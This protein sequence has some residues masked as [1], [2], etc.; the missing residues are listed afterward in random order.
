VG[1]QEN[2]GGNVSCL[3]FFTI[4]HVIMLVAAQ[5]YFFSCQDT[6]I[7]SKHDNFLFILH[8]SSF[9]G[10]IVHKVISAEFFSQLQGIFSRPVKPVRDQPN[11]AG[12]P[13]QGSAA[14]HPSRFVTRLAQ[15]GSGQCGENHTNVACRI[16]QS[17]TMYRN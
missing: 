10:A 15:V 17:Y 8:T 7:S 2:K 13:D 11:E 16:Y 1:D 4:L 6:N 12:Q 14:S 5:I 9:V 3:R